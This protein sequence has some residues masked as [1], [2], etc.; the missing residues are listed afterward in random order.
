MNLQ[1]L[2]QSLFDAEDMTEIYARIKRWA[3][4]G[5]EEVNFSQDEISDTQIEKL[6]EDGY[7]VHWNRPCLWWEVSGWK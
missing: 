6:R 1:E 3:D 7:T 5:D 2:K 4:E